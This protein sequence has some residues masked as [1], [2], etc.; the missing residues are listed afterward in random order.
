MTNIKKAPSPV[1]TF[2]TG[3]TGTMKK[4]LALTLTA[5]IMITAITAI[6]EEESNMNWAY[7]AMPLNNGNVGTI[8]YTAAYYE[9]EG[10]VNPTN[11]EYAPYT[12]DEIAAIKN[13]AEQGAEGYR[14]DAPA[15]AL[16]GMTVADTDN[17]YWY[18][19]VNA[20]AITSH[21][22]PLTMDT[23]TGEFVT[24]QGETVA[25]P[26]TLW[27]Y[28]AMP[29]NNGNVGTIY[30]TAAY[31]E[32]EGIVNPTNPEYAP[33]TADEIGAIK[34]GA[35]EGA[36]G[37]RFDAPANALIG[38]T[39]ADTDTVYWYDAVNAAAITSHADPL[40]M[41]TATGEFVTAEGE[42]V[43]KPL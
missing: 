25:S 38:M 34:D 13:G 22:D 41:D 9:L 11:P 40:T 5:L 20:V 6:A 15:N 39:V 14:F 4:L 32:L 1:N 26:I 29:L 2:G 36:E 30:Y 33:Y 18:D 28:G 17:V 10:I 43:A 31:Y 16:I 7:G 35:V 12:A 37:Y 21:A 27:A 3:K 23:A 19:A 42:A 8:Y 24:A